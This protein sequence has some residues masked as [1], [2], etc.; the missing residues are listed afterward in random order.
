M[1]ILMGGIVVLA[2]VIMVPMPWL[3]APSRYYVVSEN[4]VISCYVTDE[5]MLSAPS[6]SLSLLTIL[7]LTPQSCERLCNHYGSHQAEVVFPR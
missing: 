1:D 6:G 4:K 2:I 7:W 3:L 5:R